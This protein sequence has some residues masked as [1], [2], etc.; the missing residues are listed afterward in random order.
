MR[1]PEA[2]KQQAIATHSQQAGDFS[3]SYETLGRAPY[4]NCFVYSRR[5]LEAAL[6][7]DLPA[8][9]K[10]RR[11]LDVGCGTGHH[12]ASFHERGYQVAGVDGSEEMLVHARRNNPGADIRLGDVERLPFSSGEFDVAVCV[13]VLRY[14]PSPDAC[15]REIARVL[16]PGGLCLATAAPRFNLNGYWLVNRLAGR[17]PR[18]GLVTLQQYFVTSLGLRAAF[19]RAG[20]ESVRLRGVYLG[21]INWVER[22]APARLPGV[23]RAWEP[24]DRALADRFLLRELSNMFLARAERSGA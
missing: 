9:G 11:L 10:G 8:A 22:L 14:L 13:E 1:T 4:D 23:L 17:F 21:P 7:L 3:A 6:A 12:L 2:Q 15:L 24:W 18:A 19:R 5:R 20:F 16:R